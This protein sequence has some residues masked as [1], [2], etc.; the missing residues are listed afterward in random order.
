MGGMVK[1][2]EFES[3]WRPDSSLL[4][5]VSGAHQ[6]PY[7][8]GTWGSFPGDKAKG[9]LTTNFQIVLRSRMYES[10]FP[11]RIH[12]Y[13]HEVVLNYLSTGHLYLN[14]KC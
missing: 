6:A 11:L 2:S 10:V 5:N 8:M 12:V 3:W 4:R 9:A 7:L 13:L 14:H 1:G